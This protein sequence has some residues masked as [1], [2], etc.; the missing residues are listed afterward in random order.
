MKINYNKNIVNIFSKIL[1]FKMNSIE[2][3]LEN[4]F[5]ENICAKMYN[6][7][8]ESLYNNNNIIGKYKET[9]EFKLD[10]DFFNYIVDNIKIELKNMNII[11]IKQS[12]LIIIKKNNFFKINSK[13]LLCIVKLNEN[14]K[15]KLSY[16]KVKNSIN[17]ICNDYYESSKITSGYNIFIIFDIIL[18]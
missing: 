14:C 9:E 6:L 13:N 17:I 7:F 15:D 1:K 11:K 3:L 4:D 18:N 5:N 10:D 16:Y 8:S 12:K 2:Y